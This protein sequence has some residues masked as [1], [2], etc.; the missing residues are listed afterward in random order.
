MTWSILQ[1]FGVV[2]SDEQQGKA[3][4]ALKQ[5]KDGSQQPQ[6]QHQQHQQLEDLDKDAPTK[7]EKETFKVR[8]N[9][10]F[11]P[12]SL[13][14][15]PYYSHPPFR[16]LSLLS[17]N[18]TPQLALEVALSSSVISEDQV[19]CL[20]EA[21]N[22]L[23]AKDVAKIA[24][25]V[26]I[27]NVSQVSEDAEGA[28]DRFSQVLGMLLAGSSVSSAQIRLLVTTTHE[29]TSETIQAVMEDKLRAAYQNKEA[30]KQVSKS[31]FL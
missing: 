9:L 25:K 5:V 13:I 16:F 31:V 11:I 18:I 17:L 20:W 2:A 30:Q 15:H 4:S 12:C 28:A 10:Y 19:L 6:R 8:I 29:L 14:T 23:R 27:K 1:R 24:S 3:L 7:A 21:S 22:A 26:L